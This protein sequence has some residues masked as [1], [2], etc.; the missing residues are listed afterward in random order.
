MH[1]AAILLNA[2][3]QLAPPVSR[4]CICLQNSLDFTI[5]IYT[6]AHVPRSVFFPSAAHQACH[7]FWIASLIFSPARSLALHWML[8]ESMLT[9]C[10]QLMFRLKAASSLR[11]WLAAWS[12][13]LVDE[14][15]EDL[16]E[17]TV[18]MISKSCERT[19]RDF[20]AYL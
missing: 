9:D 3:E 14:L 10:R 19:S 16:V 12:H 5:Y 13:D 11:H 4:A 7:R 17:H 20:S 1:V 15:H 8:C 18:L 6:H 2:A